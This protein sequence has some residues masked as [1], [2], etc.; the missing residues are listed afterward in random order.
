LNIIV[1][2][3]SD[4]E[5]DEARRL[6]WG[7]YW[8]KDSL[9]KALEAQGHT[10]V[11]AIDQADVIVNC[12]GPSIQNLPPETYNV[13][14][15][16]GHPDMVTPAECWQYDAV[17]AESAEFTEH[18]RGLGVECEHLSGASDFVPM[19]VAR[20]PRAV[21]VGNWRP[22][23]V[24]PATQ[25]PLTVWGE[26]WP[27]HLPE[28]ATLGGVEYAHADLNALY[29][30]AEELPNQTHPDMEKWGMHNPRHYDILATRGEIVPTFAECAKRIMA[31]V[32]CTRMM[33]DLGCGKQPRRGFIGVDRVGGTQVFEA[34]L[35]DGLTDFDAVDVIVADNLLE[36]VHN[37]IP[38]MNSC[39]EAMRPS[40]RMHITVP[41]AGKSLDAAFSDPTH[42]R[43]FTMSTWDYFDGEH[44]RW[45]EYGQQYGILPWKVI[46]KRER[47]RFIDVMLRPA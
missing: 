38:L 25:Y 18:L 17:Y 26:G 37:L 22:G 19:D 28:G 45:Q 46:Y 42:V 27:G 30:S 23:R 15:I 10:I 47:D 44:R 40:G 32:P 34:D 33:L 16:I 9:C 20:E 43:V 24:L 14:W 2:A 3:A 12:H 29:A 41:N 11:G 36:H 39:H 13:L 7:D 8:F 4:T 5:R 6:R 31:D 35:E 21:F 1:V